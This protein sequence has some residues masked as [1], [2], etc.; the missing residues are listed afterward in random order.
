M[1]AAFDQVAEHMK[2]IAGLMA[3]YE[4]HLIA[5]GVGD[6]IIGLLVAAFHERVMN[7]VFP[8]PNPLSGLF[9]GH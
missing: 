2:P 6:A 7:L 1:I 8:P 5:E 9:G 4:R 3:S